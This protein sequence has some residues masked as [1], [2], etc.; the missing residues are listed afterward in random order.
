MVVGLLIYYLPF[1]FQA[2]L[3]VSSPESGVQ[4]YLS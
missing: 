4:I 1:Y 3:G 2:V